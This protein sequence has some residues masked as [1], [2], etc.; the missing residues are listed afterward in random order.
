MADYPEG[1]DDAVETAVAAQAE[2]E[3]TT[4]N[5]GRCQAP[6]VDAAVPE[7]N[8]LKAKAL[9]TALSDA[10]LFT[11]AKASGLPMLEAIRLEFG[12]GQLIAVATDRFT[13]GASRVEY[14]GAAF[15]MLLEAADA[16]TLIK[17][18]KTAKRDE[19]WR[20]V[21][22]EVADTDTRPEVTFRFTSGES[23][24]VRGSDLD[25]PK[26]R[27]LI[28]ADNS[29]MGGIVGMGESRLQRAALLL[30]L[31]AQVGRDRGGG[32]HREGLRR[33]GLGG[34]ALLQAALLALR[35]G[36]LAGVDHQ[37][38]LDEMERLW[39]RRWPDLKRPAPCN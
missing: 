22:V 18:A 26:W 33:G 3:R 36:E 19:G 32:L 11:A 1:Y 37:T 21:T 25:F 4:V 31:R 8:T 10:I 12:G 14:S 34:G 29:R 16:K 15:D 9:Y 17:M 13:L 28:P 27:L 38:L 24:T 39:P 35:V 30:L 6:A 20:E 2:P 5:E 23:V 7:V